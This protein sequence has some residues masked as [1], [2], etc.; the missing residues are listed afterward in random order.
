MKVDR[1]GASLVKKFTNGVEWESAIAHQWLREI[2]EWSRKDEIE[3]N[4]RG[5]AGIVRSG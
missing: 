5:V 3:R 4:T 2:V 1:I